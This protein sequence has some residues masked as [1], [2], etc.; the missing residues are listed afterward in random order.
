MIIGSPEKIA[1]MME[2]WLVND[3]CDGFSLQAP[4]FTQG[5]YDILDLLIPVLQ[6]RGL[7]QTE[8]AGGTLRENLGLG[9]PANQYL[10]PD[11]SRVSQARKE[12][13]QTR[14]PRR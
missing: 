4:Y 12:V 3:G 13:L 9:R 10:S 14:T 6:E 11:E 7:F 8:Y 1:D 2:E 5:L